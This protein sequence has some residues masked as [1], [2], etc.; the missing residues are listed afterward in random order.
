[1]PVGCAGRPFNQPWQQQGD[2]APA[3][4]VVKTSP[5]LQLAIETQQLINQ[6]KQVADLVE[7]IASVPVSR[8]NTR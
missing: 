6:A 2:Q 5:G 1:M 4:L 7:R 3:S 8:E